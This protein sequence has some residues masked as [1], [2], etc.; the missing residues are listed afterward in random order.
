M[1]VMK[2][3]N[4]KN[5]LPEATPPD[6]AAFTFQSELNEPCW[7]VV[8]FEK[9]VAERLTYEQAAQKLAELAAGK[10]S[11]LCIITDEAANRI[12]I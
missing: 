2:S 12:R 9:R 7:S 1:S 11:G 10:T 6:E 8:S 3:E 5:H 4:T